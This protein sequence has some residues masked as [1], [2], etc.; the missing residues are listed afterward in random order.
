MSADIIQFVPRPNPEREKQLERQA[1]EI[2]N[3]A[4]P[5]VWPETPEMIPYHSDEKDPA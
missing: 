3:I 1:I 5:A 4:F 2:M